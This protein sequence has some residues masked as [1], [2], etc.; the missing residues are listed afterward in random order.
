MKILFYFLDVSPWSTWSECTVTCG[1]GSRA[2]SQFSSSKYSNGTGT[3]APAY[4][5]ESCNEQQCPSNETGNVTVLC[6]YLFIQQC[7][8]NNLLSLFSGNVNINDLFESQIKYHLW[9]RF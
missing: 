9:R 3:G 6:S 8:I 1:G 2:R 4:E 7:F 5:T